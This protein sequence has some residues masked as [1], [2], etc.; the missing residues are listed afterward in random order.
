LKPE[1]LGFLSEEGPLLQMPVKPRKYSQKGDTP[2][3][4]WVFWR[5]K[6]GT[7]PRYNALML[8]SAG[9]GSCPELRTLSFKAASEP[10]AAMALSAL[11]TFLFGWWRGGEKPGDRA[12]YAGEG[13]GRSEPQVREAG[14]AQMPADR[15]QEQSKVWE[16]AK[17][18]S[19]G[20]EMAGS[21]YRKSRAD[22]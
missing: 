9:S 12:F 22:T 4:S 14:L 13:L 18:P 21:T 6:E 10:A 19:R 11:S 3:R 1:G 15:D 7:S 2:G 20:L 5:A 16:G 17:L 8:Q